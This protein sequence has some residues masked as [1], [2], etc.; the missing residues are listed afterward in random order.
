[1]TKVSQ[2]V[3][4]LPNLP[5]NPRSFSAI[6]T[7]MRFRAHAFPRSC[8]SALMRFRFQDNAKAQLSFRI[9]QGNR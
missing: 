6:V 1:M 8:V 2:N 7:S 3:F 4:L 9:L 5:P